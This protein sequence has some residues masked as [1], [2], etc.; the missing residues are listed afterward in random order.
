MAKSW[1]YFRRKLVESLYSMVLHVH[2]DARLG[3]QVRY[4]RYLYDWTG[5]IYYSEGCNYL[6]SFNGDPTYRL[7]D[8][9]SNG[10]QEA[11]EGGI[12]DELAVA[13]ADMLLSM[14]PKFWYSIGLQQAVVELMSRNENIVSED[15]QENG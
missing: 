9:V 12:I 4:W 14:L 5:N 13:V 15:P 8:N 2:W 3:M 7:F 10:I 6:L 11:L 1:H